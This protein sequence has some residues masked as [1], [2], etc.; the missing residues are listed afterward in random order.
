MA[1]WQAAVWPAALR[2]ADP[3][4]RMRALYAAYGDADLVEGSEDAFSY[5]LDRILDGPETRL[6]RD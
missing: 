1:A 4:P 6:G 5:G 3:H 2:A